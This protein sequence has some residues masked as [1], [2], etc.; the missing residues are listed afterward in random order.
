[1]DQR[2]ILSGFLTDNIGIATFMIDE[3]RIPVTYEQDKDQN[4]SSPVFDQ[5]VEFSQEF[6]LLQIADTVVLTVKDIAGNVTQGELH[7][8]APDSRMKGSH[9]LASSSLTG[10]LSGS[11][12]LAF[13]GEGLGKIIDNSPPEIHLKDLEDLQ[14]VYSDS[15]YLEGYISDESW[16]TTLK[17]NG[18][19][20]LERKGRKIFFNYHNKLKEDKNQFFIEAVDIFGNKS[21]KTLIVYRKIPKI[22][23]LDSKMSLFVLPLDYY[24]KQPLIRDVIYDGLIAALVN[25]KRFH[26]IEREDGGGIK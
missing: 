5:I 8:R 3:Q 7:I 1:M 10:I 12:Q 2:L 9:L 25:Q 20:V 14:T 16:I 24:G 15:I 17:I 21:Q 23:R 18:E 22:Y 13:L 6:D 11:N 26:L 19:S 4:Y